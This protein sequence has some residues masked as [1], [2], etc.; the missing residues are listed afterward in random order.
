MPDALE[1]RIAGLRDHRCVVAVAEVNAPLNLCEAGGNKNENE[2][3]CAKSGHLV[4]PTLFIHIKLWV[5]GIRPK[6]CVFLWG[7]LEQW[8]RAFM[9]GFLAQKAKQVKTFRGVTALLCGF[10]SD[11]EGE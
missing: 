11:I 9:R 7:G 6:F 3:Q 2:N 1:R 5:L 4:C 10:R 8:F